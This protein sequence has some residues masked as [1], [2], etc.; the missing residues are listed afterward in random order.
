[1]AIFELSETE[2][3]KIPRTTFQEKKILERQHLQNIL[4]DKIEILSPSTLIISE[5]FSD[6]DESNKRIDLLGV[7]KNANLIVIELKR[8]KTGDHMDLQAIRYASMI[9]TMTFSNCISIYQKYL[10]K[11]GIDKDA[12]TE[13][14]NFLEWNELEDDF[15]GDVNIILASQNFSKELTTSVTWLNER[16]LNIKCIKLTPYEYS[17]KIILDV[18]QIIPIPEIEDLQIKIREKSNEKRNSN[19]G[20]RDKTKYEFDNKIYGKGKLVLA[21]VKKYVLSNTNTTFEKLIS[22]FKPETQGSI[23]VIN[24]KTDVELKYKDKTNKRHFMNEDQ[25]VLIENE[26]YV[27]CNGWGIDNIYGIISIAKSLNYEIHEINHDS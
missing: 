26:E 19:K 18:N 8:T 6:W 25:I 24:K 16:N 21:I 11:R 4:R 22:I 3:I 7:D 2:I 27:V 17:G 9:S 13:L 10:I 12:E 1:M 20:Q 23:G 14:L 5:E 15:G